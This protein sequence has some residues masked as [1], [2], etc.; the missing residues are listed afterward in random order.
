MSLNY[1]DDVPMAPDFDNEA[2]FLEGDSADPSILDVE[3]EADE[4]DDLS[5][6]DINGQPDESTN[7]TRKKYIENPSSTEEAKMQGMALLRA[8]LIDPNDEIAKAIKKTYGFKAQPSTNEKCKSVRKYL[9]QVQEVTD[10]TMPFII[11]TW[12]MLGGNVPSMWTEQGEGSKRGSKKPLSSWG[13]KVVAELEHLGMGDGFK[14]ELCEAY[15]TANF[16]MKS[17][18][19]AE[20][21]KELAQSPS[22][23]TKPNGGG[24][25]KHSA[26]FSPENPDPAK[27]RKVSTLGRQSDQQTEFS[28]ANKEQ[29][30]EKDSPFGRAAKN[31]ANDLENS[32][33]LYGECTREELLAEI[34]RLKTKVTKKTSDVTHLSETVT[35]YGNMLNESRQRNMTEEEEHEEAMEAKNNEIDRLLESNSR[36]EEEVAK[37]R[38]S[39]MRLLNSIQLETTLS[40]RGTDYSQSS[41]M[42]LE[43]MLEGLD[44]T[45]VIAEGGEDVESGEQRDY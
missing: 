11:A 42:P 2:M 18:D 10:A 40:I 9:T 7:V 6:S 32:G 8:I 12:C 31:Q 14:F 34:A 36:L 20:A 35:L 15:A 1:G 5:A 33:A 39:A 13:K 43:G 37:A 23:S 17:Y 44:L 30:Q 29:L 3:V 24:T 41:T 16:A 19:V 26:S 21:A 45:D 28:T 22:G 25:A 38:G 4:S 27:R